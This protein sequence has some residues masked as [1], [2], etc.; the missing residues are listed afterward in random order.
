MSYRSD[1]LADGPFAYWF[2][3][4]LA[5]VAADDVQN[6]MEGTYVGGPSLGQS[7]APGVGEG[8][9]V[10]FDGVDD[11][12][13]APKHVTDVAVKYTLMT[14]VNVLT[15]PTLGNTMACM[16]FQRTTGVPNDM[17]GQ[18]YFW[19]DGGVMKLLVEH[20]N[21]GSIAR[22]AYDISHWNTDEWHHVAGWGGT[23][24]G[25]PFYLFEDGVQVATGPCTLDR[26]HTGIFVLGGRGLNGGV[27][28]HLHGYLDEPAYFS[29]VY[30]DP[31]ALDGNR[32]GWG[33]LS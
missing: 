26:S 10:L 29:G 15:F 25:D 17:G 18:L 31:P 21:S 5:G 30:V 8:T 7:A 32:E 6:R 3:D 22:L 13:T 27:V 16:G 20:I 9:S 14:F 11:C 33:I 23:Q 2:L 19:N 12:V 24:A 1:V 28:A 4:E